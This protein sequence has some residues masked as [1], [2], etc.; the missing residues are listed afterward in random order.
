MEE[1]KKLALQIKAV[2]NAQNDYFRNR[3]PLL[4]KKSKDLEKD[5]DKTVEQILNPDTQ[6]KL[7]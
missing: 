5:L 1:L 7:F 4:L 3:S 2:R 6:N